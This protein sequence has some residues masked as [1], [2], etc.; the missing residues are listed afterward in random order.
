MRT[1]GGAIRRIFLA[2]VVVSL[3]NCGRFMAQSP[4]D[5]HQH[6][7]SPEAAA[8]VN[9]PR[10][11]VAKD[12]IAMMDAAGIRRAVL[13]SLAYQYGNPNKPA[14]A[15]EYQKVMAE[16]DWTAAQ[17]ALY[18]GRFIVFCGVDPLKDYALAEI[19]RCSKN[20]WLKTGLKLHFGNSD[21]DLNNADHLAR[22]QRVFKAADAHGMAIAVHLHANISQHRPYGAAQ[23]RIF[24]TQVMPQAPHVVIQIA[25]LAGG[26]RI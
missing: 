25:H 13:L 18:P 19:D 6:L 15:D 22:L 1:I 17:A 10:P 8:L 26:R 21:V 11:F 3:L 4:N 24:L 2:A 7:L 12:L 5:Y 14:V 23:A 9:F 16:N 20:R